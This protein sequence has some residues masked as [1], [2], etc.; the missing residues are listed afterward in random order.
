VLRTLRSFSVAMAGNGEFD[1]WK[2]GEP[3]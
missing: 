3:V 1:P 2:D